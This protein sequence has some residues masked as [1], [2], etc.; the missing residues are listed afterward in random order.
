MSTP[1]LPATLP[2]QVRKMRTTFRLPVND[3][4]PALPSDAEL[5]AHL[6]IIG[7]EF[8]ELAEAM[9][10]ARAA[11]RIGRSIE[12]T[13]RRAERR[14][15]RGKASTAELVALVDALGDMEV[16]VEGLAAHVGVALTEVTD[17]QMRAN[18]SK[19]DDDG[20]P[21]F[22]ARG[23]FIK[24]G[25]N[26]VPPDVVRVLN[27]QAVRAA[28]RAQVAH[29]VRAARAEVPAPTLTA[30]ARAGAPGAHARTHAV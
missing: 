25:T 7:E 4:A 27:D 8:H 16:T 18:L 22:N 2:A 21:V 9:F 5:V 30:A 24:E 20:N 3:G 23:K 12:R 19:V 10:G 26:Y 28:R 6:R 15:R 13:A 17:E 29:L 11:R 1:T 14:A